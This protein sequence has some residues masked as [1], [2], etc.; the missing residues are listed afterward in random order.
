MHKIRNFT[1]ESRILSAAL[2]DKLLSLCARL[3]LA[4]EFEAELATL[5]P[6]LLAELT[7]LALLLLAL[8]PLTPLVLA[9]L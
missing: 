6:L 9:Q 8:A 1:L 3:M 2:V 4:L 7:M 5:E